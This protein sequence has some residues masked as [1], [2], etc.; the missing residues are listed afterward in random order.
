MR[1]V[2]LDL[3]N[4]LIYSYRHIM[5][6]GAGCQ[7]SC[8]KGQ[9][10]PG[11][12]AK[13]ECRLVRPY[14]EWIDAEMYQGRKISFMTRRTQ[15]L[16]G[17]LRKKCLIVPTTTRTIEQYNRI[18]TGTGAYEYVLVCNG[19]I[20]LV[21]GVSDGAWYALSRELAA[22]CDDELRRALKLL[23]EEPLRKFEL[24]FIE[25]LFVFTKCNDPA[26]VIFRLKAELDTK[27][28]DVF[29]NGEKVYVIPK[30]LSK[31]MAVQRF[32]AY[33]GAD[34][35]IAAGDSKFDVSMVEEA[36]TGIVPAGF[37]RRY[38]AEG[39]LREMKGEHVFSEEML[40]WIDRHI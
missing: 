8:H 29:G 33:T 7:A 5:P 32:R 6:D 14:I 10:A 22:E 37:C 40:S 16:L 9:E 30:K 3:D 39:N 25:K 18:D 13:E 21:N 24:R 27:R 17:R 20:L 26:A 4:T 36:D 23:E 28:V 15:V 11:L 2:H 38:Q 19:G 12:P 35:V 1:V 34:E 31:G